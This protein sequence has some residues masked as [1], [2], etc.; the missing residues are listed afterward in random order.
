[1]SGSL[2]NDR[3]IVRRRFMPPESGSTLLSARSAS[4][5]KSSSRS[6]RSA[7]TARPSPKYRP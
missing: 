7:R 6:A 4:W 2:I 1:M 3:A 5:T